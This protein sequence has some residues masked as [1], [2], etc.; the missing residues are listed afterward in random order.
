MIGGNGVGEPLIFARKSKMAGVFY[1]AAAAAVAVVVVLLLWDFLLSCHDL[2]LFYIPPYF[3]PPCTVC[4]LFS[5]KKCNA[6]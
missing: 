6:K 2:L 3:I 4:L 5:V 1:A